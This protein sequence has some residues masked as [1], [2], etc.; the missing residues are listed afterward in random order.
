MCWAKKKRIKNKKFYF[1]LCFYKKRKLRFYK[2]EKKLKIGK[3]NY[4]FKKKYFYKK[5]YVFIFK[6]ASVLRC[7]IGWSDNESIHIF[8]KHILTY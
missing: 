4:S 6:S 1:K 7:T 5:R 2:K 8:H 3:K